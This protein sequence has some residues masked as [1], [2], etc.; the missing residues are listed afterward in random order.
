MS[1]TAPS[2]C[3]ILRHALTCGELVLPVMAPKSPIMIVCWVLRVA[4]TLNRSWLV[5]NVVV[6]GKQAITQPSVPPMDSMPVF[7]IVQAGASVSGMKLP[8]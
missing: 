5:V 6:F 1:Y 2:F 7:T 3:S 4:M 8:L